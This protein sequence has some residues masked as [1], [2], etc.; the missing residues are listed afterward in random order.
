MVYELAVISVKPGQEAEFEAAARQAIALFQRAKGCTGME[1]RRS[2]ETPTEYHLSV[3]WATLE[4]HTVDFRGSEDF[5][6]WRR[7][8][9]PFFAVPPQVQHLETTFV[10][11]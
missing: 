7:L 1:I 10:G 6:E 8:V 2:V 9:G 5:Q 4:N 11:F 3:K